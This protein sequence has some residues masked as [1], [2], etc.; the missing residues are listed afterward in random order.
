MS[1]RRLQALAVML[2]YLVCPA[3]KSV[4]IPR[5]QSAFLVCGFPRSR[6]LWLSRFLSVPHQ[7]ICLCDGL[8]RARSA[9]S[10]KTR[11]EAAAAWDKVA[12]V[13]F[14]KFAKLNGGGD[15]LMAGGAARLAAN[16]KAPRGT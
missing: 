11:I 5:M 10:F 8:S 9:E 7:S 14:G 12:S 13:A 4:S 3:T 1:R 15:R 16:L 2:K 6:L